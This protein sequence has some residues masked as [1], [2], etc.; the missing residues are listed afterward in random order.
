M[1]SGESPVSAAAG[2]ARRESVRI[3]GVEYQFG[4]ILAVS[5][6]L[7]LRVAGEALL[8]VDEAALAGEPDAV[9]ALLRDHGEALIAGVSIAAALPL[10]QVQKLQLVELIELITKVMALNIDFFV[11]RARPAL[12]RLMLNLVMT[13]QRANAASSTSAS[14]ASSPAGIG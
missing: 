6:P 5:V 11:Q 12:G 2:D 14:P 13:M 8:A 3:A 7:F 4:P 10:E 1:I 9:I